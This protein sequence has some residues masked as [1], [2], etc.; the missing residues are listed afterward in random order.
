VAYLWSWAKQHCL[1][2]FGPYEDAMSTR[3]TNLFHT[4]ISGLLNLH[5]LLPARIVEDAAALEIPLAGQEGFIRQVLGWREF[6]RHVHEATDGFRE[7]P[8]GKPTVA[9]KPG[10]GGYS[11]W[12]GKTWRTRSAG[13]A[14]IDGGAAPSHLGSEQDLPPAFWG[15]PSGLACLD[16]VVRDVWDESYSHHITRLMILSNLA[17]LLD[18]SPRALTDWFWCAY[19]DA[20]DWVVEPNVLGMGTFALGDL[21]TT[22]P[23]VSGAAYIHRMSD[24][25]S[26][27]AFD[28]KK[29]CPI[30]ALYWAFLARHQK[31]LAGNPRMRMPYNSLKKRSAARRRD[32]RT[33]FERVCERLRKGE[34]LTPDGAGPGE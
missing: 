7:L 13:A 9:S 30:T 10:D 33:T 3:S 21:M 34:L 6:M 24:Y 14:R 25:C 8:G 15:E 12:S 31:R 1:P 26:E 18:I 17:T 32:D 4:R 16:R 28:P 11:T 23:Y 20:Y 22:K 2:L 5:R 29:N 27:C 19:V